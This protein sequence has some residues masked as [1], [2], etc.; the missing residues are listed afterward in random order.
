MGIPRGLMIAKLVERRGRTEM[1]INVGLKRSKITQKSSLKDS[2]HQ[3]PFMMK[4]DKKGRASGL[5]D[6][7][8]R[9][10]G[11][12]RGTNEKPCM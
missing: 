11:Q 3:V 6:L 12:N 9:L 8:I 7:K 1:G 10:G 2:S 5:A 4:G